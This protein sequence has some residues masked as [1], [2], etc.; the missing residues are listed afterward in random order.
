MPEKLQKVLKQYVSWKFADNSKDE[1][2]DIAATLEVQITEEIIKEKSDELTMAK[3][4]MIQAEE[5]KISRE[6]L[7]LAREQ[8]KDA[9]LVGG[10]IGA[11]IGLI[12]NQITDLIS[13]GKGISQCMPIGVTVAIITALSILAGLV[14]HFLYTHKVAKILEKYLEKDEE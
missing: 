13:W 7:R 4:K 3:A 9:L 10:V 2:I 11:L 14:I 8:V 5:R 1:Q 6:R 12:V